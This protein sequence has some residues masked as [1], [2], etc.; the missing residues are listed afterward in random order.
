VDEATQ[1]AFSKVSLEPAAAGS[2][3]E[4]SGSEGSDGDAAAAARGYAGPPLGM[5]EFRQTDVRRDTGSKLKRHGAVAELRLNQRWRGLVLSSNGRRTISP[6]DR[7]LV[8]CGGIACVNCSW[9]KVDGE[10]PFAK[11]KS[12]GGERL[13]PFL[14]AANPTKY[15]QPMLLSSAEAMAAGL[16]ICGFKADARALMGSFKWG[17]SFWQLNGEMLDVY[18]DCTNADDVIA[19]QNV[20]LQRIRDERAQRVADS[21][22]NAGDIY[23][24]MPLPPS[25]SEDEGSDTTEGSRAERDDRGTDVDSRQ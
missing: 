19:A 2:D 9:A 24:G 14:V 25:E 11:M 15:G 21:E 10:V 18:S 20:A 7:E 5:W 17:A 23:G 6:A 4:G 16:Y 22:A 8:G 3:D 12:V 1:R 13:L